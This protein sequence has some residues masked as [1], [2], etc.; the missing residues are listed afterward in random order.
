MIMSLE[1]NDRLSGEPSPHGQPLGRQQHAWEPERRFIP[2]TAPVHAGVGRSE[3][4]EASERTWP[5]AQQAPGK[6]EC[7]EL[8]LACVHVLSQTKGG[9]IL[10]DADTDWMLWAHVNHLHQDDHRHFLGHV[11]IDP[12][13]QDSLVE[14]S[15]ALAPGASSQGRGF[16]PHSCHL[17]SSAWRSYSMGPNSH[18]CLP[19]S[20]ART[21]QQ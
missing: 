21:G 2:Q 18:W 1:H 15:K 3:A 10:N 5:P 4:S 6:S 16:E 11:D 20:S 14:W 7:V 8:V 9:A 12:P 13:S 19:Q 17:R